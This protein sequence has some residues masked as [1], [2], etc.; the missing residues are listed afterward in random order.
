[1]L[2]QF[3]NCFIVALTISENSTISNAV[4]CTGVVSLA[5]RALLSHTAQRKGTPLAGPP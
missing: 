4:R 2:V 1:M 5:L 3:G